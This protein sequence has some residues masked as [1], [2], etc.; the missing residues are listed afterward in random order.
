MAV[1]QTTTQTILPQW[2]TQY[3][4][5]LLGRASAASEEPYKRYTTYDA[6]GKEVPVA[7]I[8]GFQP[9][10]EQAFGGYKSSMGE[11]KPYLSSAASGLVQGTQSFTA[12]GVAQQYMNPYIQNVVSGIGSTAARNLTENILPALNRTFVGGGTFGGSRS[13]DFMG[14]AVR[15][16]QAAALAEQNKAMTEGYKTAAD[17]YGSEANRMITASPYMASL[18]EQAQTQRMKEL[19]GL[20][21]IGA[22]RQG[23][24]QK[25]ADLAYQDFLEQRDYPFTQIQRLASIGGTPTASGSGTTVQS[26]PGPSIGAQ[27]AG[28]LGSGIGLI[29]ATGGFGSGG[30]LTNLFRAEGGKISMAEARKKNDSAKA[31]LGWLKD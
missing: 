7:R 11:Y 15:D 17:L 8:A 23:F 9:E 22:Q 14:R 16:T 19:A 25:S 24:A 5:N 18:G 1:Q 21:A 30:W 26:A 13:A 6:Q 31:G 2:Y 27:L 3:A 12:P 20:E 29:G 28:I 10:Q 4:Q